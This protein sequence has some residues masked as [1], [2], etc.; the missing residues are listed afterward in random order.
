MPTKRAFCSACNSIYMSGTAADELVLLTLQ[1]SYSLPVLMYAIAA[2]SLKSR[3]A[4]ELNIC[5]NNVFRRIF[6][7]NK[8]ESVKA[9]ILGLGRLSLNHLI[10]LTKI[11]F[12]RPLRMYRRTACC[13]MFFWSFCYVMETKW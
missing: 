12:Y 5:W 1:E 4:D 7:S 10:M 13:E 8:W 6:N 3:Q 2:L 11:N 9:V